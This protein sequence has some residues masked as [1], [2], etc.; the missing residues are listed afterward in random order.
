MI[1]LLFSNKRI[2]QISALYSSMIVGVLLGIIVSVMNTRFL[3]PEAFGDYKFIH[4]VYTFFSIIL[5]FGFL[6]TVS[7]LLADK[8][9]DKIRKELIGSSFVIS[10]IIGIIFVTAIFAF[11][12]VQKSFF[13]KDLSALF[14]MLSPL[15]FFI[16]FLRGFENIYQGE[17]RIYEL[18]IFRIA[19]Q[20]FYI[21][22][23]L[24]LYKFNMI[25]LQTALITQLSIFGL[26]VL[27]SICFLKPSFK[28]LKNTIKLILHE[29][30]L[31]GFNVY[32]GSVVG[33]ASTQLGPLAISFF[34]DSSNI[35][36][37]FFS[38][39]LTITMPLALIPTVVGTTMFKEFANKNEISKKATQSTILISVL[40]LGIFALLVKPLI[41]VLLKLILSIFIKP[42]CVMSFPS[43]V[44]PSL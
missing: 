33:V 1:K 41:I 20:V 24:F 44:L 29:N 19:P 17:N 22:I 18:A 38:L 30:R 27:S 4:S 8:K 13:A 31:Y 5:A 14:M 10:S 12:F 28:N 35:D 25:N 7:K 9:N 21:I 16:P 26:V 42:E 37:G 23:V 3:G 39:A 34:S 6:V 15:F 2:K 43:L 40:S 32:I 36:V 11:A